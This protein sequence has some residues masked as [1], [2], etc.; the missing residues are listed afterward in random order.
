LKFFFMISWM[1]LIIMLFSL[2]IYSIYKI[3]KDFCIRKNITDYS[4]LN[5][6]WHYYM[7]L[8]F[9]FFM[10]F[11]I[12]ILLYRI[13]VIMVI[14]FTYLYNYEG[15]VLFKMFV[16]V[17]IGLLFFN[18]IIIWT[19]IFNDK[20]KH[21]KYNK[22]YLT[23]G[24]LSVTC[25]LYCVFI[26]LGYINNENSVVKYTIMTGLGFLGEIWPLSFI[27]EV[28]KCISNIFSFSN[29]F[30]NMNIS[31]T[32]FLKKLH[33][34]NYDISS[35]I[36]MGGDSIINSST[37]NNKSKDNSY[38]ITNIVFHLLGLKEEN[39]KVKE[40]VLNITDNEITEI[41]PVD[42]LNTVFFKKIGDTGD[43]KK[44]YL[45]SEV[46][47]R[48]K[49]NQN[50]NKHYSI[51]ST[52]LVKEG[53]ELGKEEG[54]SPFLYGFKTNGFSWHK[55]DISTVFI[56]D[57]L[58]VM[59]FHIR[60]ELSTEYYNLIKDY[61]KHM[62]EYYTPHSSVIAADFLT[63]N[64]LPELYH[65][66]LLQEMYYIK[67]K[68]IDIYMERRIFCF[69]E[70]QGSSLDVMLHKK[71]LPYYYFKYNKDESDFI[72]NKIYIKKGPFITKLLFLDK[73]IER[74]ITCNSNNIELFNTEKT[75]ELSLLK[76]SY[77]ESEKSFNY[78]YKTLE[79]IVNGSREINKFYWHQKKYRL[80][81]DIRNTIR[82]I[83][84][85]LDNLNLSQ[86]EKEVLKNINEFY[87]I[88]LK[89][90]IKNWIKLIQYKGDFF[91]PESDDKEDK[92]FSLDEN[93]WKD[94][95]LLSGESEILKKIKTL[96]VKPQFGKIEIKSK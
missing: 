7:S 71:V 45:R 67:E 53:E 46:L 70:P 85:E 35:Y 10:L 18:N 77:T 5:N 78:Q 69:K 51:R 12:F 36:N 8:I 55:G 3:V 17:I 64:Y 80:P 39:T 47:E 90:L 62:K 93:K 86:E 1:L 59:P 31:H 75:I 89:V 66:C 95:L 28:G 63:N 91:D 49:E 60:K 32:L 84:K 94:I 20:Y 43:G 96:P 83:N 34:F 29:I 37:I 33:N 14:P 16:E 25:L 88:R 92:S 26:K 41:I 61:N 6:K 76:D 11:F 48:F 81:N 23:L 38:N 52:D 74:I 24:L 54:I 68:I 72:L 57:Q 44:W 15:N 21:S 82:V 4:V 73:Y 42:F 79:E 58:N 22:L 30:V 2:N 9:A 13:F 56:N 87:L 40:K 65:K 27:T 19:N 50:Q